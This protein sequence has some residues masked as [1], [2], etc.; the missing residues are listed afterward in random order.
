MPHDILRKR[1]TVLCVRH[2]MISCRDREMA[3]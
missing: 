3:R 2:F 1:V